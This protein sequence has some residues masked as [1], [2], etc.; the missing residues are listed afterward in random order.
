MQKEFMLGNE[1]IARAAA[2]SGVRVVAGYPGTPATEIVDHCASFPGVYAE[3]STNEKHAFEVATAASLTNQRAMAVM[4]H[5]GTNAATD[6]LMHVNFTGIQAGLVLISADDPGGLS[7]Q[8]EEDTRVLIHT[9]AHLPVFDPSSVQE[10]Y[11]MTKAA[12]ELSEKT[13]LVFALRPVMRINHAGGMIAFGEA[14]PSTRPVDFIIDRSRFVMSAVVEKE[15]GGELRP[16]M[17]HR[18]LNEK[19]VELKAVMEELPFNWAE[20]GEGDVGFIGCGIGYAFLKEAEQIYGKKLPL[21]K[22]ST[23]PLPEKKVLAFIKGLKKV[24]VFEEIEPVVE[25]LLK[26]LCF[27]EK[28]AVEIL[29][30]DAYLPKEGELSAGL[31]LT[32]IESALAGKPYPEEAKKK[33]V[34]AR[35]RTQCSG[36]SHRGLLIAMK[37]VVRK[38]GG[39]VTGDIGCH[40]AGTFEPMK[41]QATIYCMGSSIPMAYGVKAAGFEKPVY[42]LIGDSTFFHNGLT[43]LASAIY[44]GADITVVIGYNSTTAMTG[45]QPH[46][47]SPNNLQ[48]KINPMEPG[49]VAAAMG[50]KVFRCNPYNVEET[51]QVITAATAEKGV[52]VVVAEALCYL[53]FSREGM[54]SFVPRNVAVNHETCNGCGICVR[55]FGCP[56]IALKDG[57][58]VIDTSGCNGCGVCVSVCKRGAIQ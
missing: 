25:N 3:W 57:K 30:R 45:F 8:C 28:V 32:G 1:A 38:N 42:A 43:G 19:Q 12:F 2:E 13:Q 40:D 52:K 18:W 37:E 29:G 21:L 15:Y 7:S 54:I 5:N 49:A 34:P 14:K 10:A 51:V 17:R 56:A 36:C 4:K 47:G 53:R 35:T 24:V 16:K 39:V 33:Y 9:Y 6:F 23:L 44:N 11:A 41:L 26:K 48:D 58:A 20:A 27:E 46:P 22:L 55:T 31:V 50:A